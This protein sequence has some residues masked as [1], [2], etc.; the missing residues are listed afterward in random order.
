MRNIQWRKLIPALLAALMLLSALIIPLRAFTGGNRSVPAPADTAGTAASPP[1]SQ[2]RTTPEPSPTAAQMP[3]ETRALWV[4]RWDLKEHPDVQEIVDK[5][6]YAHMNVILFQVRG[7]ADALYRSDLEPWSADL[8]GTLGK[9]PGHDPLAELIERAHAQGIEV[10]AWVNAYAAWMGDTPPAA[11]VQPTPMYHEFNEQYGNDWIEWAG[12]HPLALGESEYLWANPAHPAVKDRIVA[13][14]KDLLSRYD[15]DGLHLDY[16]RY[17]GSELSLDPVS[18]HAYEA[19]RAA[20]PALSREDWQRSQV[21][22]LVQRIRDEALPL[23][24]GAHLTTSAWPAYQDQ[25]GWFKGNDGYSGRYQ[26]SHV[27]AQNGLVDS[28]FPMLY[29]PTTRDYLDRFEALARD[30]VAGT[31]PG[32][33]VLG[34]AT[35]YGSFNDI[36]ARIDIARKLGARGQ[37]LFSYRGLEEHGYWQ[38]LRDGPYA[39]PATPNW[40]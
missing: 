3:R 22:E 8:S 40:G 5:A 37:A 33:A 23:R 27:W 39:E 15:L 9:D 20:H 18:N 38:A 34:I 4:S 11:G 6:A 7:Q 16:I 14:C 25:W 30:H 17:A 31:L 21:T 13:V 2:A 28:I 19:A 10:H 1:A 24:P 29:G 12:D 35:D 32:G 26:D 36:A